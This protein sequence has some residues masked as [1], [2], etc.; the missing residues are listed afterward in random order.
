MDFTTVID[1]YTSTIN[2]LVPLFKAN[3]KQ[4]KFQTDYE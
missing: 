2:I 3:K 4:K 1:I